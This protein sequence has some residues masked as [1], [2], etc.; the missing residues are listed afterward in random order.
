MQKDIKAARRTLLK[1]MA[2]WTAT[3]TLAGCSNNSWLRQLAQSGSASPSRS[4]LRPWAR[5]PE[6]ADLLM[7]ADRPPLLETPL[8]HFLS[9]LTPNDAYFV[10]WHY[11]GLPTRIDLRTFRLTVTG[12]V[13]R[14]LQL[15]FDDLLTKFEPVSAVV[16]SQCAG[17]SRSFFRPQVPGAEWTNGAMGNAQYKGVRLKDVLNMAGVSHGAVVASFRGLDAPPLQSSPPFEK[18][19]PIDY[20]L[21]GDALIAYE[22]NGGLLPMLNGYPIRLVVPG[23]F[24]TYWMKALSLITIR[25][26]PLRNFWVETA[27]RIPATQDFSED[28]L[29]PASVTTPVTTYP[30]RSVFITPDGST[31]MRKSVPIEIQGIAVDD[32]TGIRRVEVS[33]DG[34]RTWTDASL[35]RVIEKFSWRR[36]R[37]RWTPPRAGTWQLKCRATNA[38]GETQPDTEWNHGGYRRHSIETLDV[39]VV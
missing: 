36:W 15:S 18:P 1:A 4:D 5:Y 28:H 32:G 22:M 25:T 33:T 38:A 13:T 37:L 14:P 7:L 6:K 3:A 10:R 11:A 31:K 34:G 16:F 24:A 35:D 19:L 17:N 26:E 8:H 9:D 20:A 2:A 29:H 21:S 12:A 39:E 23:W 30:T 27:Y